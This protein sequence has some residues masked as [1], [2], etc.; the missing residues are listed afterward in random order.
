MIAFNVW[1]W[2][3]P[4]VVAED[5]TMRYRVPVRT[6]GLAAALASVVRRRYRDVEAV[7]Q[8]SFEIAPGE[9]VGFIGP[10]G[11]GKTTTLKMLSG[12]LHPTSGELRVLGFTP[13]QRKA[14]FLKR[15][16]LIRGSQ[17]V[18]GRFSRQAYAAGTFIARVD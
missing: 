17:P 4:V 9:V 6:G 11:A 8:V 2:G 5:L 16:A 13:G 12:L 7:R 3:V 14:P 1:R 15:I 10:N 18:G